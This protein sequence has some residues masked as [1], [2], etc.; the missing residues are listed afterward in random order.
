VYVLVEALFQTPFEAVRR[1]PTCAEPEITGR[2]TFTGALAFA[3]TTAVTFENAE[4]FP[5]A[6]VARTVARMTMPTWAAP[7]TMLDPVMP[8]T[9]EHTELVAVQLCHW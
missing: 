6:L 3:R 2:L 8:V 5:A 9:F 1:C 7:S 4:V